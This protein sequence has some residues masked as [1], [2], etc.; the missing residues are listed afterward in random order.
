MYLNEVE[1]DKTELFWKTCPKQTKS[2]W[3]DDDREHIACYL[4]PVWRWT[5]RL[6]MRKKMKK[7][8]NSKQKK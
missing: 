5:I 4:T 2:R 7:M 6:K 3:E 8:F 1:T